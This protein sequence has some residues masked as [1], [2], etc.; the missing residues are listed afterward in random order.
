MLIGLER[1]AGGVAHDDAASAQRSLLV[2]RLR[3]RLVVEVGERDAPE[4]HLERLELLDAH[5]HPA[6][7]EDE[8][9][10]GQVLVVAA[11]GA[12]APSS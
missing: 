3:Q 10:R 6:H 1:V 9:R 7:L 2:E 12:E 5:R 8:G 11:G 4:V